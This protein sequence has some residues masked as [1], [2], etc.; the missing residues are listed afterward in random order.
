M[1]TKT[2]P[3]IK[4]SIIVV[5]VFV[6]AISAGFLNAYPSEPLTLNDIILTDDSIDYI[7]LDDSDYY[8]DD[9]TADFIT[10]LLVAQEHNI[11]IELSETDHFFSESFEVSIFAS[12]PN[13]TIYYTTNG[14]VPTRNSSE[15]TEP[16]YFQARSRLRA[17]TLKAVAFYEEYMSRV[18]THTFFVGEDVNERFDTLIFSLTAEH[19]DLFDFYTG[20]LVPGYLRAAFI[21]DNPRR[22]IVPPDPANFNI[23]GMEGERPVYVEVFHPSGERVLNQAAGV[24]VHGGWSRGIEPQKSLRL[25]ARRMYSIDHGRFQYNFFPDDVAADGFGTPIRTYDQIILSN[26]ANDRNF[27]MLRQEVNYDLAARAGIQVVS[28]FRAASVFINGEYYGFAWL[29]VRINEQYL[30]SLF[31]APT[32]EFQIASRGEWWL[33]TEDE[34]TREAIAHFN[35]FYGRDFNDEAIWQEFN[36]LVDVDDLMLYYAFQTFIGNRDWPGGNL[37]RWR[38][39]GPQVEGLAPELDGRWRFITY[40]LD[41]L[42]GLYEHNVNPASP[43][44][45]DYMTRGNARF[46]YMLSTIL[47]RP[48]M[49]DKYAMIICDLAANVINVE[50]V[51][52]AIDRLYSES[53]NEIGF[54]LSAGMYEGWVS[55]D[56]IA[57]N[58][59][60]MIEYV[61]GRASPFKRGLRDF[62]GWDDDFFEVHV[63]GAPAKIGSQIATSS[64]YFSH[65]TIPVRPVLPRFHEFCHWVVNGNQVYDYEIF[66]SSDDV[67][68]SG[69]VEISLVTRKSLPPLIFYEVYATDERSGFTLINPNDEAV[70]S[71]GLFLSNDRNDL[72]LFQ[73][74]N[75][76]LQS[77]RMLNFAGRR[78]AGPSDYHFIQLPFNV[79][80]D[81]VIILSDSD[82]NVLD[83]IVVP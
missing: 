32:R 11:D 47:M 55:R 17:V 82:G 66:V 18:L 69:V 14:S 52:D 15:F 50:N 70:V 31:S 42:M 4:I 43:S 73:I 63:T 68:S 54:A 75:A 36:E 74:P 44:F 79:R 64:R 26:N 45:R 37:R 25:A 58:H 10:Q 56:S 5:A 16:L 57:H 35:S 78:G 62:F 20:I 7:L 80:S 77:G 33:T 21:R 76:S 51:R 71:S 72:S 83:H 29:N 8:I 3:L 49:A 61:E 22:N 19:D 40:D 65:L 39:V 59:R 1:K 34:A 24:R 12:M 38:Y 13:A 60:Q 30:Q 27:A 53:S 81:R 9:D 23:R 48:D 41:F 2:P 28:P 46:S 67:G 6:V